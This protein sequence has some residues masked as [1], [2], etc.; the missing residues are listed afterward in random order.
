MVRDAR[1]LLTTSGKMNSRAIKISL[2]CLMEP[3]YCEWLTLSLTA[4]GPGVRLSEI[5]FCYKIY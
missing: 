4:M 1:T 5:G 3:N 2:L